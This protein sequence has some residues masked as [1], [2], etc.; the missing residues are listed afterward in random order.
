MTTIIEEKHFTLRM[1]SSTE[2]SILPGRNLLGCTINTF[3]TDCTDAYSPLAVRLNRS[4]LLHLH[5]S[6]TIRSLGRTCLPH[7][8]VHKHLFALISHTTLSLFHHIFLHKNTG[9]AVTHTLTIG[10]ASGGKTNNCTHAHT[11]NLIGYI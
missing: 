4:T 6:N 5:I 11:L 7:L 9:I 8:I 1:S 2:S 3:R 10:A